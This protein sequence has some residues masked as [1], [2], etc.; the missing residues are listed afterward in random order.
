MFFYTISDNVLHVKNYKETFA[1]VYDVKCWILHL[2]AVTMD[3][4]VS[5]L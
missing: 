3:T 4:G 1:I 5:P 2:D